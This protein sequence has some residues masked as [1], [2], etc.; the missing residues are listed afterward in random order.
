MFEDEKEYI[1]VQDN[2]RTASTQECQQHSSGDFTPLGRVGVLFLVKGV[3]AGLGAAAMLRD[4]G[5]ELTGDATVEVKVDATAG[6]GVAMRRGAGRIRHIATPT[7]WVQKL[8]QDG[9]VKVSK[10]PGN[11]NPADL[12]SKAFGCS[13]DPETPCAMQVRIS[14]WQI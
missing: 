7:L 10:I 14:S 2:V 13:F 12:G 1:I 5:V 3:A 4:L 6:R 11:A 9:K 8:V